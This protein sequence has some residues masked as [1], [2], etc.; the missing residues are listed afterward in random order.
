MF[1]KK[2]VQSTKDRAKQRQADKA[3]E[4]ARVT[5]ANKR[6]NLAKPVKRVDPKAKAMGAVKGKM[7]KTSL[8]DL[9]KRVKAARAARK[10]KKQTKPKNPSKYR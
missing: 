9:A 4:E 6:L 3:A 2:H 5:A 1:Q 8:A 10:K 7:R